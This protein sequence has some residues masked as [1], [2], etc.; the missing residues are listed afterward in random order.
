MIE[1]ESGKFLRTVIRTDVHDRLTAV[2]KSFRTG[3]DKWDYGVAIQI[4]LDFYE[5]HSSVA[6]INQKL[7]AIV[8]LIQEQPEEEVLVEREPES[9]ELLGG[10]KLEK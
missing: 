6:Q 9:I 7:D 3:G 8:T 2:A 5:Q 10:E 1:S 4:L